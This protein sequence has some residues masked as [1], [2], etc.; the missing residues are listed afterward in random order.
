M[1]GVVRL[2]LVLCAA[3]AA[4]GYPMQT[5]DAVF[6][7]FTQSNPTVSEPL[8]PSIVSISMSSFSN[9][10][11]TIIAIHSN[12]EGVTGNFIAHL[13]PAHLRAE[14]VNILAVDWSRGSFGYSVGVANVPQ[15]GDLIANFVNILIN[16]F[17]YNV[18]LIRIV[19]FGL[20]GHAAGAAA[21]K[22]NGVVPHIV[23]LDPPLLGWT[24]NPHKLKSDDAA[25]VEVLHT[26]AGAYGYGEP[27]GKIDFY[28]NGG[29]Q[30]P[31]CGA[32]YS[33]SHMYSYVYYAESITADA[34]GASKFIGTACGSRQDAEQLTC[35]GNRDATFGGTANKSTESGIYIFLTNIR[36]P[37][38]R[39]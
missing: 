22:I 18:N 25:F 19:G 35:S 32:D 4:H 36:P 8:L 2:V 33:C 13:V 20:G 7:L 3:L 21:R 10:R 15:L 1:Y 23:A 9:S 39:G 17:G 37:F 26:S 24:H 34:S 12:G 5:T 30:Q 11:K 16:S 29:A 31:M 38:A 28:A 14:D 6:H 27:L